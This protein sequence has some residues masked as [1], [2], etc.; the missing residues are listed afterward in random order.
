MKTKIYFKPLYRRQSLPQ[1]FFKHPI[2]KTAD[3]R[4]TQMN[5]NIILLISLVP[6]F[7]C[8]LQSSL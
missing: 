6:S 3:N 7:L 1:S 8:L 4:P 2:M 5:K